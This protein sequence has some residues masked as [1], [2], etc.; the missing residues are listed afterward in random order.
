MSVKKS[1]EE[2]LPVSVQVVSVFRVSVFNR[3]VESE[4]VLREAHEHVRTVPLSEQFIHCFT[5]PFVLFY[6]LVL[7]IVVVVSYVS[8]HEFYVI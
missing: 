1:V 4:N 3:T 6:Q 5:E 7:V 8:L 2:C